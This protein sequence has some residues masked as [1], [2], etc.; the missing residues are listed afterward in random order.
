[1]PPYTAHTDTFVLDR[2]PTPDQMPDLVF[3]LPDLQFPPRL[4]CADV[5]LGTSIAAGRGDRRCLITDTATWT[6]ANLLARSSQIAHVLVE[7]LKIVPGNRVLLVG[8]NGTMLVAG[9]YAA[10]LAGAVAVTIVPKAT[11]YEIKSYADRVQ[12]SAALF[13]YRLADRL[14]EVTTGLPDSRRLA[15]GADAQ[16][17]LE[18]RMQSK[19]TTFDPVDTAATDPCIIAFTSGSGGRPK[20]AVHTH[21]DILA[22]CSIF[23]GSVLKPNES[24]VFAGSPPL[25]FTFGLMALACYPIIVGAAVVLLERAGPRELVD[26][27]EDHRATVCFTAPTAYRTWIRDGVVQRLRSLRIAVSSGEPMGGAEWRAYKEAIGLDVVNCL[28]TTELL[29]ACMST[30]RFTPRPGSIGRPIRG[31]KAK[32]IDLSGHELTGGGVGLLAVKGPTGCMY[33]DDPRQREQVR[34]G[35]TLTGDLARRDADGVY[36]FEGRSDTMI[37]TAGR[38]VSPAE[39]EG[40]LLE[41]PDVEE[42]AVIPIPDR[43]R[44]ARIKAVVVTRRGFPNDERGVMLL[45][46]FVMAKIDTY[47]CPHIIEFVAE[48]PRTPSGKV[49]RR[50]LT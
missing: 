48:L 4:N 8:F 18:A 36:W 14:D 11:G 2:M 28:G 21:R 37:V 19:P 46:E 43:I 22:V 38:N 44:S 12:P 1:M 26:A 34:G 16:G 15:W 13:D 31:Y 20:A 35:W 5:L 45:K 3:D 25:G 27:I 40:V 24:D 29:H 42:C 9:W 50:A 10:M 7:D 30:S 33:L 32:I 6:Y 23:A 47:K 39:V 49:A 17:G 41:H